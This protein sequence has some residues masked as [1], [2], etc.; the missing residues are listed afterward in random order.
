MMRS[1]STKRCSVLS[2]E[3]HHKYECGVPG[4]SR[5]RHRTG[6]RRAVF[7][8]LESRLLLS[9][10]IKSW[11]FAADHLNP[12]GQASSAGSAS[13]SAVVLG[14][15]QDAVASLQH[16]RTDAEGRR[17]SVEQVALSPQMANEAGTGDS[18]L[19][20]T[21]DLTQ[22]FLLQS[23]SDANHTLYLDFTG[24]TTSG[25]DWNS[26]F[27]GGQDIVT[28]AWSLDSDRTAFSDVEQATIQRIWARV[29]EDYAPF[30][31]NVTTAEPSPSDLQY[32][33]SGDTRWGLRV[34]LGPN[35]WFS[36][37]GGVA[38]MNSF[39]WATSL[40][41]FV[42]NTGEIGGAETASHEAGHA[43]GLS[44]DGT[45]AT[46]Y[47]TGQGSGATSWAP[48]MGSAYS[49]NVTQWSMNTYSGANNPEDD[50]AIIVTLNGF[51]YR[52]D[53]YGGTFATATALTPAGATTIPATYGIIEKSTDVDVFS[54]T[55]GA[56]HLDVAID[57]LSVGANLDILAELHTADGALFAASN[58]ADALSVSLSVTVPAAGTYYLT[59]RGTG[60][61]DPLVDGYTTYGSL[62]NYRITGNLGGVAAAP[63]IGV[64]T[65]GTDVAD[66]NG[67]VALGTT[68]IGNAVSRT[69]TVQNTGAAALSLGALTVPAGFS[70]SAF[71]STTLNPGQS[72]TFAVTLTAVTAGS[73]SGEVSFANNDPDENPFGSTVTGQ[74]QG[75]AAPTP[76]II[77]NGEAGY[78][79]VG[80]WVN[81]S[82]GYGAD[83][84]YSAAGTGSQTAN[85]TFTGLTAGGAYQV[86]T[87]WTPHVN[88][89][90]NAPYGIYNGA[91]S[92][93]NLVSTVS[94]NQQLTPSDFQDSGVGWKQLTSVVVTGTTLSIR[95][96]NQASGYVIADAVRVIA[97]SVTAPTIAVNV[98]GASV[99]NGTGSLAFG[100]TSTGTPVV[101]TVTVQNLG[102]AALTLGA[103]TLPAG[104]TASAFGTSTVAAGAATTFT[105]TLNAAAAGSYSGT[106]SFV[107]NDAAAN[108]F[109]FTVSGTVTAAAPA[110]QI[111]D[112]G[113]TGFAAA[114]S[115]VLYTNGGRGND[116]RYAAAG[117][118]SSV[119][120]WGF[121]VSAAGSYRVSAT[122]LLH[123]NRATNAPFSVYNGAATGTPLQTVLVNQQWAPSGFTDS[124][125]TWQ[126]LGVFAITASTLSVKLTN[127]ANG[128]VIAD[129]IRI[130]RVNPLLAEGGAVQSAAADLTPAE[131]DAGMA[132][133]ADRWSASGLGVAAQQLVHSVTA[134]LVDLPGD[135]ASES[136]SDS[137]S[138]GAKS[139][140]RVVI[141][142]WRRGQRD[143]EWEALIEEVAQQGH[144][145]SVRDAIFAQWSDRG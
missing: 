101:R 17:Y 83:G 53:D 113:D 22:T 62:G 24:H 66:G 79:T 4:S 34:V 86:A 80:S 126:D 124:G 72:T 30:N 27:T 121:P 29:A 23:K 65:N 123:T 136:R 31:I 69:F 93:G 100:S 139:E 114:G 88:R 99:P 120:T 15:A 90:T 103:L 42:F 77:D 36:S 137:G 25:T 11:M 68:S 129:A 19:W 102:T 104:F 130:E 16:I 141:S 87:T 115:W 49:Q 143:D 51:G 76:I 108:P 45:A 5:P 116:L 60:K 63:E 85:W 95:L 2:S 109:S 81:F 38:Y 41:V 40:P 35:T 73:Y 37:C 58:P 118:G 6:Q 54:F 127:A 12:S 135:L 44:H 122:W 18:T 142:G 91:V 145:G 117:S 43:L 55:A 138:Q 39:N 89:A 98:S 105:V 128:Y 9:A 131:L 92:S 14:P 70:A 28:P 3:G 13:H 78:A 7:E 52:V 48:I 67:T 56:G 133:A 20:Q 46:A 50:L 144:N 110:A 32:S 94:V 47:Y 106:V 61:G 75:G 71:G 134:R 8:A 119:A 26:N 111:I 59:V 57:P 112:D 107:T 1:D 82:T 125:S 64:Q 10:D 96:T 21:Y 97:A 74:V 140:A 33:G 132:I 84:Q